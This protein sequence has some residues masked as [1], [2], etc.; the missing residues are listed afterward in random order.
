[1]VSFDEDMDPSTI[2][3]EDFQVRTTEAVGYTVLASTITVTQAPAFEGDSKTYRVEAT[4]G[5]L[6][7]FN[8]TVQLGCRGATSFADM[9]GNADD[10]TADSD[11]TVTGDQPDLHARQ[12]CRGTDRVALVRHGRC[13]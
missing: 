7:D 4:G 10:H 12:R 13:G 11:S 6:T 8:G 3:P 2:N 9:A 1:M 5:D